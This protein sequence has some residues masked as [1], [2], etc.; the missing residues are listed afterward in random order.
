MDTKYWIR[1]PGPGQVRGEGE[2]VEARTIGIDRETFK[3]IEET[4]Y[5]PTA[6]GWYKPEGA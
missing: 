3:A 5:L 1:Q 2:W 4:G 6:T